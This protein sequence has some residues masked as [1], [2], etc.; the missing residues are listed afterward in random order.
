MDYI[1]QIGWHTGQ[2][3][4]ERSF[5]KQCPIKFLMYPTHSPLFKMLSFQKQKHSEEV[6]MGV[7]QGVASAQQISE[8]Y[9]DL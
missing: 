5:F 4:A 1:G 9:A 7:Q 3:A 6:T 8:E 2:G